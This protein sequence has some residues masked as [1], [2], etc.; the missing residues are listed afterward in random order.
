MK[1]ILTVLSIVVPLNA[2]AQEIQFQIYYPQYFQSH[3]THPYQ[4]SLIDE[5]A[6]ELFLGNYEAKYLNTV[7]SK[8][9]QVCSAIGTALAEDFSYAAVTDEER[10]PYPNGVQPVPWMAIPSSNFD[11]AEVDRYTYRAGGLFFWTYEDL[12]NTFS[13]T[14]TSI[15]SNYTGAFS[16]LDGPQSNKIR[17]DKTVFY[18]SM[19][20]IG[21]HHFSPD[22]S[23]DFTTIFD[24]TERVSLWSDKMDSAALPEFLYPGEPIYQFL[25]ILQFEGSSYI[26]Y[27]RPKRDEAYQ[28]YI[29]RSFEVNHLGFMVWKA[30]DIHNNEKAMCWFWTA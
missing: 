25:G 29:E 21:V 26:V 22:Y 1:Y 16:I 11:P 2:F 12:S 7:Y 17:L 28:Q 3:N 14:R 20:D 4:E 5:S 19:V 24:G 6:R 13:Y 27:F 8:D 10:A 30:N 15:S 18:K 23:V 9:D